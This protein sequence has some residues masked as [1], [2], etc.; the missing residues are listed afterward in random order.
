MNLRHFF[1]FLFVFSGFHLFAA[2]KPDAK[3]VYLQQMSSVN[4]IES[5]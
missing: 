5:F 2:K 1:L 4:T 3:S